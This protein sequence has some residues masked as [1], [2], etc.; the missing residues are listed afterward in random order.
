MEPLFETKQYSITFRQYGRGFAR[1]E[2]TAVKDLSL[3]LYAGEVVAVVGASG[4]GK[5]L[6]A[7]GILGLLPYNAAEQGIMLYRGE[8]LTAKRLKALRGRE[9]VLIPQGASCLNPLMKVGKQILKGDKSPSAR[10]RMRGILEEYH[11][12][13]EV[14]GK[15]PFELSGGMSRRVLL[16]MARL[17]QPRLV[18]ADE[19]TP[20]L[21]REMAAMALG[22]LKEMAKEGAGVLLITHDLE[23]ALVVA[24]RVVVFHEGR[25]IEEARPEDFANAESLSHPYTR[26]LWR[27]MPQNGFQA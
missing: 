19:P 2:F 22:H 17:E 26:A 5:S 3:K 11:L 14:E 6:L 20:G 10:Q 16:T 21:H 25:M 24:D 18:V 1:Q 12:S 15:Y 13:Q 8:I 9:I 27:A 4:S 7:H 23:Q